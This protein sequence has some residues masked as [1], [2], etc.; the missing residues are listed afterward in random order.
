MA[1][2]TEAMRVDP[3]VPTKEATVVTTHVFSVPDI[4]CN[5]CKNAIEGVLRALP[6]VRV[7]TVNVET[8]IVSVDFEGITIAADELAAAIEQQGYRVE[9]VRDDA[10]C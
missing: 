8:A 3:A 7:A 6:G 5:M 10:G 1:R 9:A 4:S 2:V